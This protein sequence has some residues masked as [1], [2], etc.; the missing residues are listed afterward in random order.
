MANSGLFLYAFL[1]LDDA[2]SRAEVA[3]KE[4]AGAIASAES[5]EYDAARAREDAGEAYREVKAVGE[6]LD[7]SVAAE[8]RLWDILLMLVAF[9]ELAVSLH[10]DLLQQRRQSSELSS[11]A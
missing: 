9:P 6:P 7:N 11:V 4:A 2:L 10:L 5:A 1:E 3:R 8:A